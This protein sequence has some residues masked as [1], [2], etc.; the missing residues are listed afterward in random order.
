MSKATRAKSF[1]SDLLDGEDELKAE[2]EAAEAEP[3]A[4]D[5]EW[6]VYYM[7]D[8]PDTV[9]SYHH[10]PDDGIPYGRLEGYWDEDKA[11][12]V[13]RH[14]VPNRSTQLKV[15]D[16]DTFMD[17]IVPNKDCTKIFE[18]EADFLLEM[19]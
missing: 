13:M 3:A 1:L 6:I 12:K 2:I 11:E 19:I 18:S 14:F 8:K 10:Q 7:G 4:P 16:Y 9:W 5:E 15:M 17:R